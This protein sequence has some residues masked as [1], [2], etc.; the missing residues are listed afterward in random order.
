M[1][2][3]DFVFLSLVCND[4]VISVFLKLLYSSQLS[5]TAVFCEAIFPTTKVSQIDTMLVRDISRRA[6]PKRTFRNLIVRTLT[7][8][9]SPMANA[10]GTLPKRFYIY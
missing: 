1:R 4:S 3:I 6:V 2:C 5:H 8:I 7:I 9:R 10:K